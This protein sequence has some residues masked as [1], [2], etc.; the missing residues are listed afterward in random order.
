[1]TVNFALMFL[2][3]L[4]IVDHEL[5]ELLDVVANCN[6]AVNAI[7]ATLLKEGHDVVDNMVGRVNEQRVDVVDGVESHNRNTFCCHEHDHAI[8]TTGLDEFV[9][10]F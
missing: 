5:G 2:S 1:M 6:E 7:E 9:V 4:E 8:E 3:M 10:D